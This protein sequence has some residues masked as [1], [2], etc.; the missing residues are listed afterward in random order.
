MNRETVRRRIQQFGILPAIRVASAEDAIFA[1]EA[2]QASGLPVAE[3]TMTIP[4][5]VGVIEKLAAKHPDLVVGA[6][7]VT[8]IEYAKR[9]LDAGARF[10]SSPN[11]NREVVE[12]AR[13]HD[14]AVLPGAL[15]P[16]EVYDAWKAGSDFV[17][18]YPCSAMG[19]A[20][21]IR[22]LRFPLPRIPL[23]ASGGVTQQSVPDYIRAGVAAVGIGRDLVS[24]EAIKRRTPDWFVVLTRRF[25]DLVETARQPQEA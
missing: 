5:A 14:V 24:P 6:G 20:G 21:Y 18:V 3:V 9:C 25:I 23:I 8:D 11:L 15:T 19:G 2:I 10:L 17:K 22:A 1:V 13:K 16:T 7:T 12:F 4:G